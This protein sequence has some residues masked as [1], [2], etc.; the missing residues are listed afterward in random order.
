P[1]KGAPYQK[2]LFSDLVNR[3]EERQHMAIE[4]G[5]WAPVEPK[6]DNYFAPSLTRGYSARVDSLAARRGGGLFPIC[7]RDTDILL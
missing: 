7:H 6:N 4:A 3:L 2:P 5:D 1:G